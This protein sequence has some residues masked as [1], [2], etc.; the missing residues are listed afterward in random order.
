MPIR[1][2][3]V[4]VLG[5]VDHG[6]TSFLDYIRATRVAE[7]ESGKIT[8]HIGATEVPT[9]AIESIC[10]PLLHGK[11]L[12]IPGL[13]FIDTPGHNAFTT[14]RARGGAL[15]DLAVLLVDINEGLKPQTIESIHILRTYKTPFV[16]AAN[17]I[18]LFYG[19]KSKNMPF[20]LNFEK[21]GSR[22]KERFDEKFYELVGELQ[23]EG[24]TAERYD[25][26]RDFKTTF[27]IVPMSA[28]TG[29]GIADLLMVL[30]GLAQRYLEENLTLDD[31]EEPGEAT[32][33]EV[34][35][36]KG[37]GKALDIILFRGKI[38]RE[39][40]IVIGGKELTITRVKAIL[41]P[42]PLDEIRDPKK[43]FKRVN[44]VYA[45]AGVKI[46]A[47]GIEDVVS[48]ASLKVARGDIEAVKRKVK[49]E[50]IAHVKTDE[51]G[52]IIKADAIGSLE[53]L[54]NELRNEGI[55]IKAADTGDISKKDIVNSATISNP[56]YRALLGFNVR[57]LPDAAKEIE[58]VNVKVILSDIIYHL[59][60]EYIQW[61]R[62]RKRELEED[63]RSE[64][65][66]PVK[67][68]FLTEHTFRVSKPALI[69]V[70]VLAGRIRSGMRI[71][72][73]DGKTVG[74]IKSIRSGD[75]AL[76]EAPMGSEVAIA[77][78]GA[79]VGRHLKEGEIYYSDIPASDAKKLR[80]LPLTLEEREALEE[81]SA[82][83][84]KEEPFWGM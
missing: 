59:V 52:V 80:N 20:I 73:Q 27:S 43:K 42:A 81:I 37:L 10:G 78:E 29:E 65:V 22:V 14:L 17:K 32:V 75:E 39:D 19:Y 26:V 53:A 79:V 6:K 46:L 30:S 83:K 63:S 31:T 3:I 7:R 69:G 51:E 40:T 84:R 23:S 9:E 58:E 70:R 48:G 62:Q 74:R 13:L 33:L 4:S 11:K 50:S 71:M 45:A 72:R 61:Y 24:I 25:R 28:K 56:L 36:E 64:I 68:L 44:E 21:Q 1:Q 5:H 15:A 12:E 34:K 18:D 38:R 54:A 16:I 77:V 55:K 76:K 67:F 41:R 35:E 8:Q 82:I 66:Y 49:E 2:P 60:E 47:P 57:V